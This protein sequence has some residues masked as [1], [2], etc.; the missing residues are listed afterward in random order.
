MLVLM[1]V[2]SSSVL[3]ALIAA[4]RPDESRAV[5]GGSTGC[6]FKAAAR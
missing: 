4:D 5:T 2:G 6:V 1:G 3:H